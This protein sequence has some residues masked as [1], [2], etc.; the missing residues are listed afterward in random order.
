MNELTTLS[1]LFE[2][3]VLR[4]PD[5]QRGYSWEQEQLTDFWNDLSNIFINIL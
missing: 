4:I 3:I 1:N 2:K 5:Y